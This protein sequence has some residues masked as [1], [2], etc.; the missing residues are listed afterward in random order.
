MK[1]LFYEVLVLALIIL[2]GVAVVT[3]LNTGCAPGNC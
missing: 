3:W 2:I 1:R